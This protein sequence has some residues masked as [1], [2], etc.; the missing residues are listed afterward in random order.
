[1]VSGRGI[2]PKMFIIISKL[3]F[4]L[5]LFILFFFMFG[6]SAL[7]EYLEREVRFKVKEIG[8]RPLDL[9]AITICLDVVRFEYH[10]IISNNL[11]LDSGERMEERASHYKSV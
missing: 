7:N 5:C 11:S 3:V 4:S 1:M 8:P 10:K 9:P 6:Q 2:N